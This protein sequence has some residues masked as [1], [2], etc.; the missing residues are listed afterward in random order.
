L[1]DVG[2]VNAVPYGNWLASCA[3]LST[4]LSMARG[5]I[6]SGQHR[7]VLVVLTDRL[8]R[9]APRLMH[10]GA[11]VTSDVA[12]SCLIGPNQGDF[13]VSTIAIAS[14]PKIA[15][16]G[17]QEKADLGKIV[18]ETLKGLKRLGETF[19]AANGRRP[20]D[21]DLVVAGHY[22]TLSLQ[23]LSD[24]LRIDPS[25]LRRDARR[26]FGHAH[27][28]DNLLT[29]RQMQ[30]AGELSPG[31]EILLLNTGNWAWSLVALKV[32]EQLH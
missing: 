29:L 6:S 5:M 10:N 19:V 13:E 23:V 17:M 7:N 12:T 14:A 4:T 27:A 24:A 2:L 18:F 3:N 32:P 16:F 9:F 22:H 26:G 11:S 30:I 31:Q 25:R 28:S 1:A 15:R 8:S 20:G 21:Y